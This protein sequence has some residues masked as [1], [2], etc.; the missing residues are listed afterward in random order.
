MIA[1]QSCLGNQASYHSQDARKQM[2][3]DRRQYPQS[4]QFLQNAPLQIKTHG[5]VKPNNQSIARKSLSWAP[6]GSSTSI[7]SPRDSDLDP[8]GSSILT[9]VLIG[10]PK[11]NFRIKQLANSNRVIVSRIFK[12]PADKAGLR[13]NDELLCVNNVLLSDKPRS[14]LLADHPEQQQLNLTS[15]QIG[16]ENLA[17][18][19]GKQNTDQAQASATSDQ[20]NNTSS[21]DNQQQQANLMQHNSIELSKL[22]FAYQLIKHSSASNKL[23]LTVRRYPM[24]T[25][26]QLQNLTRS[27]YTQ[28]KNYLPNDTNQRQQQQPMSH[29]AN[30]NNSSNLRSKQ[31]HSH[32]IFAAPAKALKTHTLGSVHYAYRC[33]E[34]Y[35]DNQGES[36]I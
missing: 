9:L 4:D 24:S 10:G 22:D 6:R 14:L 13:V 8:T 34:C 30:I 33:C 36:N 20:S 17:I 27:A 7:G 11:W 28:N 1:G 26:A 18:E 16:A 25:I 15:K 19:P 5:Y 32:S 23:V 29:Q 2:V 12:G 3:S 21:Q 31:Q 35:C